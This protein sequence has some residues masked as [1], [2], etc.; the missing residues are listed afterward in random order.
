MKLINRQSIDRGLF[1]YGALVSIFLTLGAISNLD[2]SLN[3]TTF[4]LFLPVSLYFIWEIISRFNQQ[5]H[6]LLNYDQPKS[7][8][9]FS[10]FTLPI[11]FSQTDPLFLTTMILFA[12]AISISLFRYS[13]LILK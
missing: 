13:L 6:N 7:N 11:F 8:R 9:Y 12:L 10:I 1:F 5:A 2:S 3:L 4:F